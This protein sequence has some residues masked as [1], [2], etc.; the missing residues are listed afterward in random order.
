MGRYRPAFLLALGCF[1]SVGCESEKP[2]AVEAKLPTVVVSPALTDEVTDYEEFTGRVEAVYSVDIRARVTGYL[3]K[4]HFND[5]DEVKEGDLLFEIDA[6][7]YEAEL[8]RTEATI[9]QGEAH[10]SRLDADF[11]R[12]KNLFT[13]G[14]ISR[15]EYDK[16]SGDRAEAEAMLGVAVSGREL[17]KLNVEFTKIKAPIS[18]RL[19]RRMADP[20]NLVKADETILTSVV[21]LDPMYVYFDIDEPTVLM[22]RRLIR[23]GRIK[24]RTETDVKV[25]FGLSDEEG[26]P[27]V[28]TINFSDNKIEPST[29]TLRVRAVID[30]P[31]AGTSNSRVL[32]PGLFT[33]VR[34]PIGSSH[35]ETLVPEDSIATDQGRK[36]LYVIKSEK[37]K[38]AKSEG[39][40]DQVVIDRTV[41]LGA[42]HGGLRV[43]YEGL[44]P[45]ELV[46]VR[47]HQRV[48]P[49][50]K[51]ETRLWD[52]APKLPSQSEDSNAD[53]PPAAS[54][55]RQAV[56]SG[57]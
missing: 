30:N 45:D 44:E 50:A 56:R 32:S 15:E 23:E 22:I 2:K 14:N 39:D 12:A 5:G 29:G 38:G 40:A 25:Y 54:T 20:G 35:R 8:K 21:S 42:S 48:R 28:G 36:Y 4:V 49:G 10:L 43:V 33:R 52:E 7:P 26:F 47:G 24:S 16:F 34:L 17:A 27:H 55:G 6:R 3:E 13:R 9:L 41:K 1:V 46:V 11:R 31:V 19:S 18:G 53:E 51:V 37:R 57:T